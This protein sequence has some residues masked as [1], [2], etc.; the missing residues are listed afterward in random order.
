M[1]DP[2]WP[3]IRRRMGEI[4]LFFG[5][6][7]TMAVIAGLLAWIPGN[8]YE[9]TAQFP[10]E[11][12]RSTESV[13]IA[14]LGP[15][16]YDDP[17]AKQAK[18]TV[19]QLH[20]GRD[21]AEAIVDGAFEEIATAT[22][23]DHGIAQIALPLWGKGITPPK[24]S[25]TRVILVVRA[26]FDGEVH[27]SSVGYDAPPEARM[28]VDLD[29][30][31]YQPGQTIDARVL[32]TAWDSG[33]PISTEVEWSVY[34]P[35]DNLV[36]R[37]KA[38]TSKFGIASVSVPLAANG[39]QGTYRIE[40]SGA[41]T[42]ATVRPEVRPFRLPRFTVDVEFDANNVKSGE[43]I[44]GKVIARYTYGEPVADETVV[45]TAIINGGERMEFS[46]KTNAEGEFPFRVPTAAMIQ[47]GAIAVDATVQTEAG[48]ME[49]A[50]ASAYVS[51]EF[52]DRSFQLEFFPARRRTFIH[53]MA[54][55]GWLKLT[56]GGE[57]ISNT[58]V[59]LYLPEES[60]ERD[61]VVTTDELGHAKFEWTPAGNQN[62][63]AIVMHADGDVRIEQ[64]LQTRHESA[65]LEPRK[66]RAAPGEVVEVDIVHYANESNE[67]HPMVL[68][69]RG[70]NA[71]AVGDVEQDGVGRVK[72]P[73][74]ASGLYWV[75]LVSSYGSGINWS[76]ESQLPIW[77]AQAG[78]SEVEMAFDKEEY[79]PGE[80][81]SLELKFPAKVEGR[82]PAEVA[83]GVV[84]VDEALY[85]LAER[86]TRAL[87]LAA[88]EDD[89]TIATILGALP[90]LQSADGAE[91]T[92]VRDI[93]VSKFLSQMYSVQSGQNNAYRARNITRSVAERSRYMMQSMWVVFCLTLILLLAAL[94]ARAT[95]RS[96]R[97]RKTFSFKRLAAQF[98]LAVASLIVAGFFAGIGGE[99]G[100]AGGLA[101]WVMVSVGWFLGAGW[102]T[103]DDAQ[104]LQW[105][106]LTL[107]GVWIWGCAMIGAVEGVFD[108]HRDF[109][110][111]FLAVGTILPLGL[112]FLEAF[113][114]AVI[115]L[116]EREYQAA[117][118]LSSLVA[119]GSL[120]PLM[121]TMG[122]SVRMEKMSA[123]APSVEGNFA[124][125]EEA[126]DMA[127]GAAP[128]SPEPQRM[129]AKK[130]KE[131][132]KDGESLA[133]AEAKPADSGPRV[134][135]WFPETM[136]WIAEVAADKTG[137]ARLPIEFPDSITTWR[138]DAWANT[139]DGR[140]G[141]GQ[142][143]VRTIQTFFAEV[144]VPTHLID[145]DQIEVPV[146]IANR[147][148]E[149]VM[150]R[151]SIEG[152]GALRIRRPL[153]SQVVVAPNQRALFS[154]TVVADGNGSGAVT[155]T[156]SADAEGGGDAV[157]R[158]VTVAPDGPLL[159]QSSSGFVGS[160]FRAPVS[161]P[162]ATLPGTSRVEVSIYASILADA[163]AGLDSMLRQPSGCFEQT[164][165]AN[166]PNVL[167]LKTLRAN[168]PETWPTGKEGWLEAERKGARFVELG[169]Q[170]ML[171]FQKGSGGFALYPT[172]ENADPML[173]AYGLMQ[174]A[175][176][177]DVA[178]ID[179]AVARR[180]AN[181]LEVIQ[182]ANGA[183]PVWAGG[184]AGGS[185]R[186]DSDP[187]QVR[188]T[189]FIVMGL[190]PWR[191]ELRDTES[192]DRA[193]D[194]IE[195]RLPSV[196]SGDTLAYAANALLMGGRKKAAEGVLA[197][198]DGL[199]KREAGKLWWSSSSYSWMG[200][201]GT[202]AD[203]ETTAVA[204][205]AVIEAG[206]RPDWLRPIIEFLASSRSTYG[207]WGSTQATVWTLRTFER[208]RKMDD[209]ELDLTIRLDD[210]AMKR[211][212]G[213]GSDGVARV[214]GK[215]A[216][217]THGFSAE[218]AAGDS[219]V[220]ILPPS[221]KTTTAM[222]QVVTHYAVAWDSREAAAAA[223]DLVLEWRPTTRAYTLGKPV[224]VVATL[225]N[226]TTDWV[227]N[228]IIELPIPP[229]AYVDLDE[230]RSRL[231]ASR[232]EL[233]PTHIRVYVDEIAPGGREVMPYSFVPM[234]RGRVS[235]PPMR[236]YPFYVPNPKSEVDAGDATVR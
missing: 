230:T 94:A 148:L 205:W 235:V 56:R 63:S 226:P 180:A 139:T 214:G 99:E 195:E 156:A 176:M 87:H 164:S 21:E 104:M 50:S 85:A 77:V 168:D 178:Q 190:V 51:S 90:V 208:L 125:E 153:P 213:E 55:T 98:G 73:S 200:G 129:A 23:N 31:L 231:T 22:A 114:W 147:G 174:L 183:W 29:R 175:E 188:A 144:E 1:S 141:S 181:W 124:L 173:T 155:V 236:A 220:A 211:S 14:K 199:A 210:G 194:R 207:G 80:A 49:G 45:A 116:R 24:T 191:D 215:S 130:M 7:L 113:V 61:V 117:V 196:K 110:Q 65:L 43:P 143:K 36:K 33:E 184:A 151:L 171:T 6:A 88:R 9:L 46:G 166:Y 82:E 217:L 142:A 81:G 66:L 4:S 167:V 228:A 198:L 134:R 64:Y 150:A 20:E 224:E 16:D 177:K 95:W 19:L 219:E 86:P 37:Q 225:E 137:V 165:S 186:S 159:S 152:D 75:A 120:G 47:G 12:S 58:R 72:I 234:V 93:A 26:E 48:R 131:S 192:I 83:Y 74:G 162:L 179:D 11:L 30:P 216:P 3:T 34:D 15:R 68:L 123:A 102:R 2:V 76:T 204:S 17:A 70:G 145:G 103:R 112:W 96:V 121:L 32:A 115:M 209:G 8:D 105:T 52:D 135:S 138:F 40:V 25:G 189:S 13:M 42:S 146:T 193:L 118:A 100:F 108:A 54:N 67:N 69:H 78:G 163:L 187:G 44:D 79:R 84:A 119:L 39:A 201:R 111:V 203:L 126:D 107:G 140:F 91:A 212:N 5:A 154:A 132:A 158:E 62:V 169:Y 182:N 97:G 222:A 170:R 221:G 127:A 136:I 157:R 218:V 10:T 28:F 133:S 232:V 185:W 106:F 101:V 128:G 202:Y 160:G 227:A 89:G 41:D 57:P 206:N 35:Q 223:G 59:K 109:A 27:Y 122:S 233:L 172:M 161:V 53:S 92:A 38:Q 197:R 18:F 149:P 71:V 60:G 229:G